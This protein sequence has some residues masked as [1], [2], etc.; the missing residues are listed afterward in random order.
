MALK[1]SQRSPLKDTTTLIRY[2]QVKKLSLNFREIII[3]HIFEK[4]QCTGDCLLYIRKVSYSLQ[5]N[6]QY[7]KAIIFKYNWYSTS[8]DFLLVMKATLLYLIL[9]PALIKV[10]FMISK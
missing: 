4:T 1:E 5:L 7:L 2:K 10:N 3:D 9:R 6:S 8:A